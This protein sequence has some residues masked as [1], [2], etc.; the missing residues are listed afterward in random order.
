[1]KTH[2]KINAKKKRDEQSSSSVTRCQIADGKQQMKLFDLLL[3][4]S[5][6]PQS[7]HR[8][9]D[10]SGPKHK[11]NMVLSVRLNGQMWLKESVEFSS[12]ILA[13]NLRD[14]SD[15]STVNLMRGSS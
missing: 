4:F 3:A 13:S 6:Y 8:D 7:L 10:S 2:T 5:C 9:A 1:V 11:V 15:N 12:I 14:N